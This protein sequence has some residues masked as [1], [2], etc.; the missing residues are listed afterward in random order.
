MDEGVHAVRTE[1]SVGLP[2]S[3]LDEFQ[4]LDMIG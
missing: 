3:I 2:E 1:S 4:S